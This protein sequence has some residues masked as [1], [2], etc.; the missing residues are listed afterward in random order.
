MSKWQAEYYRVNGKNPDDETVRKRV[1]DETSSVKFSSGH[2]YLPDEDKY[3]VDMTPDEQ[4]EYLTE[5]EYI[6]LTYP[7][8]TQEQAIAAYEKRLANAAQ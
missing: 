8:V 3:L 4:E 6:R 1:Q 2:W 7:Y 5:M